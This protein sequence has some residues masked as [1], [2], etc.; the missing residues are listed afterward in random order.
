M[1]V[2][3]IIE[4]KKYKITMQR[5]GLQ[6]DDY[7]FYPYISFWVNNHLFYF[8]FLYDEHLNNISLV[9]FINNIYEHLVSQEEE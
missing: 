8:D 1:L 6:E 4:Q 3:D 2:K 9:Q 7:C 5:K